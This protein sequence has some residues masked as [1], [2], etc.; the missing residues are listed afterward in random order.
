MRLI[1]K[2]NEPALLLAYR[3]M[4]GARY[5]GLPS[6]A[7]V[8]ARAALIRDQHGLCC[9]CSARITAAT[10]TELKVK[11]AHWMPQKV[12]PSRD[13]DWSN[14]LAACLGNEGAPL[15]RQHCDTRQGQQVLTIS[16]LEPGHIASLSYTVRGEIRTNRQELRADLDEKLNLNDEALCRARREAVLQLTSE[17]RR[18]SAGKFPDA[19]LRRALRQCEAPDAAGHLPP[20]AGVLSWWLRRR[21]GGER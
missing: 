11:I 21:L 2:G 10:G 6:D 15:A 7:K 17:L 16:P 5:S 9:F 12:D 1:R 18:R 8:E 20:F 14:L 4:R 3:K 19:D 13:L